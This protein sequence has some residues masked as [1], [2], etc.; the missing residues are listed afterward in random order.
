MQKSDLFV[1]QLSYTNISISERDLLTLIPFN[2]D[3]ITIN[4]SSMIAVMMLLQL[5]MA[6]VLMA[7]MIVA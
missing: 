6:L 4:K 3:Q 1:D 7:L 5:L 2:H